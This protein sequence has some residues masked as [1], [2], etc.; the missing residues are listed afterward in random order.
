MACQ[1][2]RTPVTIDD[3]RDLEHNDD[4]GVR[5]AMGGPV[6]FGILGPTELI[7]G[8]EAVALGP[9]KQRGM[10]AALLY[11][12]GEPVRTDTIIEL[13]WH[14]PGKADHR[15][16][17]YQL[18][19]RL[20]AVLADVGLADALVRVTGFAAYRLDV[21]P[22]TVDLHQFR[23]LL[24]RARDSGDPESAAEKLVRALALWRGDP[25]V[26]LRGPHAEQLRHRLVE[27]YLDAHRLLAECRLATG[28]HQSVLTQLESMIH[29]HDL[30]EALARCWV[31]AL[32]AVD[33]DDE[34]RRFVVGFRRRFRKEMG[35]D[36]DI[37]KPTVANRAAAPVAPRHLPPDITDFTGRQALLGELDELRSSDGSLSNV[38]V[39]TGMPGVGKTTLATHWAHRQRRLFPDGQ[40]YLDAGAHGLTPPVD[41]QDAIDRF[42]RILGVPADQLPVTMEQRRDRFNDLI[43]DRRMLILI[44]NVVD[45]GQARPLIPRSMNC[46]TTSPA[47]RG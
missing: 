47:G 4:G 19:S 41:P 44:D 21:D 17:L 25:L 36:P 13:L 2:S 1:I 31:R 22:A 30:D 8:G 42:L 43:G 12:A 28:R 9:A 33:R 40:L 23:R 15:P 32:R 7:D 29:R 6:I 11:H 27:S 38:V 3:R 39:I 16:A 14:P 10:L 20:R 34:A 24:A 45:S 37:D 46:L 18:A 35:T 5:A 26:E